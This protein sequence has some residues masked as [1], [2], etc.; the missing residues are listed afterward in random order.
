MKMLGTFLV[1]LVLCV[2]FVGW[3]TTGI[4]KGIRYDISVGGHLKRAADANTVPLAKK[5]LHT[6]LKNIE[7]KG[8]TS[9]ST[10]VL[11]WTPA[12]DVGYWYENLKSSLEELDK[13][14][15]DSTQLERT[16][17]LMKLRE[18]ILDQNGESL[19][20]TAPGGISLHP[21]NVSYFWLGWVFGL[22]GVIG[23]FMVV[24]PV[25]IFFKD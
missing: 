6:A 14:S 17:L 5:E 10:H 4:V 18:T 3:A 23:A 20:V 2:P 1:G 25:V 7:T 15:P 11:W 16:N 8:W 24:I 9:G 21:Y 12:N 22:I 19:T 13:V